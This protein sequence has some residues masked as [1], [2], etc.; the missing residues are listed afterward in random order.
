MRTRVA[1]RFAELRT[2]VYEQIRAAR[3]GAPAVTKSGT[4]PPR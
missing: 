3:R 2:R 4:P 1:P